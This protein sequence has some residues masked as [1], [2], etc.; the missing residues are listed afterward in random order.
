MDSQRL[1]GEQITI[2]G[3]AGNV[4]QNSPVKVVDE[5]RR[6]LP[7]KILELRENSFSIFVSNLPEEISKVELEAMFCRAGKILDSF[8]PID[9]SSGKKRGFG[10]IRF[11]SFKEAEKGMELEEDHGEVGR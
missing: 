8:L 5:S 2:A 4:R 3:E 9:K 10:F 6:T 11:G 1:A 7:R